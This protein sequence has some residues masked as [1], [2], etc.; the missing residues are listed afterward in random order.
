MVIKPVEEKI[1]PEMPHPLP[2]G[3]F[4]VTPTN[5]ILAKAQPNVLI[6]MPKIQDLLSLDE[7][8]IVTVWF[9]ILQ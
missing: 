4:S 1:V 3:K 2:I 8:N 6:T 5:L 7:Y 9:E